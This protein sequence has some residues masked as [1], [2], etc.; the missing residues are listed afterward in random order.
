M[1]DVP[2]GRSVAAVTLFLVLF[3][4]LLMGDLGLK[5][6]AF[7]VFVNPP[8][9][10]PAVLAGAEPMPGD[11][12]TV[13]PS[14]LAIKLTL[15]RGAVF[16]MWAGQRV[17]F[18]FATV[19]AVAVVGYFF[20]SSRSSHRLLHIALAMVLAGALGNLYD[21]MLYHAVRDML[22]MLPEV[23]LPFG[24][25]WPGGVRDA[26]PWIFNLADVYLLAGI[27]TILIRSMFV[28]NPQNMS[29]VEGAVR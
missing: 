21:R 17:V 9:E 2:A 4:A 7:N 18:I 28:P 3:F 16:G 25:T 27:I 26:Y 14:A 15:N 6:W 12:L 20:L 23:K 24:L 29:H 22:W 5:H 13:I 10:I 8:V 1:I 11:S 19:L